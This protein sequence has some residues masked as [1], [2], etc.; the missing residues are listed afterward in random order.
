[1][2]ISTVLLALGASAFAASAQSMTVVLTDGST[3]KFGTDYVSQVT[4]REGQTDV[5]TVE[6]AQIKVEPYSS[7]NVTLTLSNVDETT[8]YSLDLYGPETAVYLHAGTYQGSFT[9]TEYYF[10]LKEDYTFVKINGQRMSVAAG[11]VTV[12][13]VAKVY[14]VEAELTLS[15]GTITKGKYVGELAK[16]SQY[17]T[18][19][20]NAAAYDDDAKRKGEFG[21]TF[22]DEFF[23]C[24][25]YFDFYAAEDATTLPDGVYTYSEEH[26]PG[27]FSE[28]SY[29]ETYAPYIHS[30]LLEGST[31]TVEGG[32]ITFDLLIADGR[33]GEFEFNGTITGTPTFKSD[34]VVTYTATAAAYNSNQKRDKGEFYIKL[35]DADWNFEM[36]VD[37]YA[38][39]AAT[40]LPA[41][42]YTFSDSKE[43]GTF[44]SKSYMDLYSPY[45]S[46]TFA[47]GSTITVTEVEGGLRLV[48]DFVATNGDEFRVVFEGEI[49][50]TPEF[51][52]E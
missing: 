16:Y 34:D 2:R 40:L 38:D 35:N 51:K 20:M 39:R 24:E 22:S 48:M 43:P 42:T 8:V 4:L 3:K 45:T 49:T 28:K 19:A 32:T 33:K 23:T 30:A 31:I 6:M 7:G 47:E 17:F 10:D 29:F 52:D 50:G 9:G 46:Y 1:M 12:S 44:T 14:T 13:N 18:T 41:G 25:A 21:V 36:A 26:T 11:T 37:I 5:P 27:T 15:D